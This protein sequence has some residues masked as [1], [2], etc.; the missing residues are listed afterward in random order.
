MEKYQIL[1]F[2]GGGMKGA[3]SIKLLD[4]LTKE[5]PNLLDNIKLIAGTSTGG[6]I[7][8][9]LAAGKTPSEIVNIYA[10]EG[11][12]IFEP[13]RLFSINEELTRVTVPK[14]IGENQT[15]EDLSFSPKDIIFPRYNNKKFKQI[16]DDMFKATP[17]IENLKKKVLVASF[18]V[19]NPNGW[20]PTTISN[21]KDSK[22]MKFKCTDAALCTSAAPTYFP[23]YKGYTDGGVFANN[24]S[25]LAISSAL[26]KNKSGIK[27][28]NIR[29]ISF[30]T[31][32]TITYKKAE[33]ESDP[34]GI[35]QWLNPYGTSGN[36]PEAPLLGA[37]MDGVNEATHY[38]CT[39]L[40]GD[41]Q[42]TRINIPLDK[43]YE[44]DNWKDV[45]CL[46]QCAENYP[47]THKEE[48]EKLVDWIQK[49]FL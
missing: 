13:Y 12:N 31:G 26:D 40:L 23:L 45:D 6:L 8:L 22:Y 33:F 10:T 15:S 49:F 20:C 43:S 24:P 18:Q 25:M 35:L 39:Q 46:F 19:D 30:G 2:D 29:L 9:G 41:D 44:I 36:D 4:M 17:I 34:W 47:K 1:S 27:L 42:Y 5:I 28:E 7:A 38:E 32:D 11:A 21:L 37:L 14:N 16:L 48:W 3:L